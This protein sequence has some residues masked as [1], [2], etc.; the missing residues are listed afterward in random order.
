MINYIYCYTN[1]INEKKYVGQTNNLQRRINEHKSNSFNPMSVNYNNIIHKAIRKYGYDNF[2]IDVLET[3]ID[4]TY[5]EVNNREQYWIL[6]KK[7]LISEHGYNVI[8]VGENGW[9]SIFSEE[10]IKDIKTMIKTQ[11]PYSDIC[12]KYGIS[13]TFISNINSGLYFYDNNENYPL[14]SYRIDNDTYDALIE[15]LERPELTFKELAQKYN[16]A[17]STVKKFN[18]G[19]LQ[20]GYYDGEYPIRKLTPNKYRA[21]KIIDY[22][23]N[24]SLSKKEIVQLTN[25]SNETVRKI[26]LGLVHKDN[27]LEYPLRKE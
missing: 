14:C 11:I 4:A 16:L 8:E 19:T 17:E 13:K 2:Q 26:N 12:L 3:L 21:L 9:H 27:S 5:E 24:T 15:D 22:L 6:E 18:Y 7:S 10:Q 20:H 25:S 23:Q 1:L